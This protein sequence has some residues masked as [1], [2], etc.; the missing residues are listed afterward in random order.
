MQA[1]VKTQV[2]LTNKL[3][4][5][6]STAFTIFF[7]IKVCVVPNLTDCSALP[8]HGLLE[9]LPISWLSGWAACLGS[10]LEVV[11]SSRNRTF[12][13]SLVS[14]TTPTYFSTSLSACSHIRVAAAADPC[15]FGALETTVCHLA[16]RQQSKAR[17]PPAHCQELLSPLAWAVTHF[18]QLQMLSGSLIGRALAGSHGWG[19]FFLT[20]G[21]CFTCLQSQNSKSSPS[22]ASLCS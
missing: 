21:L 3:N 1:S 14:C 19:S 9:M 16:P 4:W 11:D 7:L 2:W 13:L 15:W 17:T 6:C 10:C 12:R 18:L 20:H 8:P 22:S 5:H